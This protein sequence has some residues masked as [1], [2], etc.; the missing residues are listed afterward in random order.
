MQQ[1]RIAH[2]AAVSATQL[3][4]SWCFMQQAR[5]AHTFLLPSRPF[6]ANNGAATDR[7]AADEGQRASKNAC[8]EQHQQP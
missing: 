3:Q 5:T 7:R 8:P 1:A 4:K 2:I 6:L